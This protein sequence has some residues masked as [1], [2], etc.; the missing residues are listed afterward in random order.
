MNIEYLL[1]NFLLN[2]IEKSIAIRCHILNEKITFKKTKLGI[3]IRNK[4][5]E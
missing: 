4:F 1:F 5:K 2:N 3:F